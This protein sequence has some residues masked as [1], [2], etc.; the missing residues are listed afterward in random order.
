M[1]CNEENKKQWLVNTNE[2]VWCHG[3]DIFESK[4]EAISKGAEFLGLEEGDGFYIGIKKEYF[5]APKETARDFLEREFEEDYE[6][7]GE[8]SD[9]WQGNLLEDKDFKAFYEG[10]MQE[11][12][13]YINTNHKADFFVV[14]EVEA[15]K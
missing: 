12:A 9:C 14:D 8:W 10:K 1:K 5:F 3:D 2:E 13:D 11:I 4:E 15:V 7:L 6:R